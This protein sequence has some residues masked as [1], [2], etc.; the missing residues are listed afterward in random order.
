MAWGGV[1]LCGFEG[2]LIL[3]L[4]GWVLLAC[5]PGKHHWDILKVFLKEVMG[6]GPCSGYILSTVAGKLWV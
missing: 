6:F 2:V 5:F 4:F 3:A 1:F